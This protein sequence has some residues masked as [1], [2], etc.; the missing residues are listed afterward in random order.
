M[1]ELLEANRRK[2]SG[3]LLF[4]DAERLNLVLEGGIALKARLAE[5]LSNVA[6]APGAS[7]IVREEL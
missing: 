5:V 4:L 3:K 6:H 1:V 2:L 7:V